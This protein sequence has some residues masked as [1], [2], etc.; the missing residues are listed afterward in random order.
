MRAEHV[1]NS[2]A[3]DQKPHGTENCFERIDVDQHRDNH[4]PANEDR[5]AILQAVTPAPQPMTT[6]KDSQHN[7]ASHKRGHI[8]KSSKERFDIVGNLLR[9]DHEHGDCE[10]KCC[11][12]ESLQPRHLQPAQTESAQ[13]RQL[14]EISRQ[15]R[16]YLFISRS[17]AQSGPDIAE[18]ISEPE[19]ATFCNRS[20]NPAVIRLAGDKAPAPSSTQPS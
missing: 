1:T 10:R 18:I 14:V 7:D 5:H 6:P 19:A 2:P 11:I 15:P 8:P 4:C 16:C 13:A 3:A 9:G 17:G 20:P 12:D